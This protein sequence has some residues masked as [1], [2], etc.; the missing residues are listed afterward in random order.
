MDE[1]P[2]ALFLDFSTPLSARSHFPFSSAFTISLTIHIAVVMSNMKSGLVSASGD[3]APLV[4][5]V[6]H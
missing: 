6:E 2:H 4:T 5:V 3:T 1:L